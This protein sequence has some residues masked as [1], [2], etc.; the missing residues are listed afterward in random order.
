MNPLNISPDLVL[1][2]GGLSPGKAHG[3]CVED[4]EVKEGF[5]NLHSESL[6]TDVQASLIRC[7]VSPVS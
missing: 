3:Y 7:V 2:C 6:I 1:S 4:P 5:L